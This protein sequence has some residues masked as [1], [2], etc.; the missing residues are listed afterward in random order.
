MSTSETVVNRLGCFACSDSSERNVKTS[1]SSSGN[2]RSL[3]HKR[4]NKSVHSEM[5]TR[6]AK[7]RRPVKI[8]R[9]GALTA[10]VESEREANK[11][12]VTARG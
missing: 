10:S 9:F 6:G 12:H 2:P 7:T 8:F 1:S 11:R 4:P 3:G 5:Q